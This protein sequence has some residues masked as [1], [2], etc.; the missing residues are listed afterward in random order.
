MANI[1]DLFD[2]FEDNEATSNEN[3]T[4]VDENTLSQE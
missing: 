4:K 1:D 3:T 2:C